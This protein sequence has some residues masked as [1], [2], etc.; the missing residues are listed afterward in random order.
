[1]LRASIPIVLSVLVCAGCVSKQQTMFDREG[2]SH[3]L[4]P[5]VSLDT[6]TVAYSPVDKFTV[7]QQLVELGAHVDPEGKLRD[8][9]G[10]EIRFYREGEGTA[11]PGEEAARIR[12]LS[13]EF[14]V[15]TIHPN[16]YALPAK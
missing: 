15:V 2:V 12:T 3:C 7:E 10:K 6:V 14:T 13:E 11:T 4:P 1:M 5:D 16:P 9:P 8:G